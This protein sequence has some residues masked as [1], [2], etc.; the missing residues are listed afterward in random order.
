[1]LRFGFLVIRKENPEGS[2]EGRHG[3]MMWAQ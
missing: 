1:M 3:G 2:T